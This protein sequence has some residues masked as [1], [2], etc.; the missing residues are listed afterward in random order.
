MPGSLTHNLSLT[1]YSETFAGSWEKLSEHSK[2]QEDIIA[3]LH[4][5]IITFLI[6]TYEI[7]T[8]K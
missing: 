5:F 8:S 1:D 7:T 3:F 4:I 6:H 2:A